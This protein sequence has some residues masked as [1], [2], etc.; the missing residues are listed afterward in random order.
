MLG[1]RWLMLEQGAPARLLEQR[2]LESRLEPQEQLLRLENSSAMSARENSALAKR[3]QQVAS[4][5]LLVVHVLHC[6]L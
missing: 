4:R 5:A 6:R 2:R 1:E 3:S